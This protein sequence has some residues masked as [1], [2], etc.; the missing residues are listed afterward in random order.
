[1]FLRVQASDTTRWLHPPRS[2]RFWIALFTL[3][4]VSSCSFG[5][6]AKVHRLDRGIDASYLFAANRASDEGLRFGEEFVSTFGPYCYLIYASDTGSAPQRKLIGELVLVVLVGLACAAFIAI[7]PSLGNGI[8]LAAAL[9]LVYAV[10]LQGNSLYGDEYRWFSLL[11]LLVVIAVGAHPVLGNATFLLASLLGGFFLLVKLS[12]GAGAILALS[13]ACVLTRRPRVGVSRI[14][15]LAVGATVGFAAAWLAHQGAFAGAGGFFAGAADVV[16]GYGSAM[17]LAPVGWEKTALCF[18]AFAALT[19]GIAAFSGSVRP[20]LTWLACGTPLFVAWKHA[21]VREDTL[22]VRAFVLFG[23]FAVC[24]V[25]VHLLAGRKYRSALFLLLPV[26]TLF[27]PWSLHADESENVLAGLRHRLLAPFHLPGRDGIERARAFVAGGRAPALEPT[28][29][30]KTLRLPDS[31][32]SRI[33]SAPIDVY[34]WESAYVA[35]NGL[36]WRNRPSPASFATYSPGLDSRNARFF[37]STEKPEYLLWHLQPS[38]FSIDGRHLFWDE[39]ETLRAIFD[40]YRLVSDSDVLLFRNSEQGRLGAPRLFR[41]VEIE[42]G[43]WTAVP[44]A[45]GVLF[46]SVS[47]EPPWSVRLRALLLREDPM[48]L[49][50]RFASGEEQTYRFVPAQAQ[51]GLWMS[52]L[53]RNTK[54]LRAVLSG[55]ISRPRPRALRLHGAWADELRPKVMLSW[56]ASVVVPSSSESTRR[57]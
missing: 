46:A 50:V 44:R 22:H 52:P 55:R 32:R 13:A 8:A 15:L 51:S 37:S 3:S 6:R 28:Q 29:A 5:F 26:A 1:V 27:A 17:S 23:F 9:L 18:G 20:F 2:R 54:E 47:F 31:V 7:L 34:P 10:H 43:E 49:S 21:M 19:T 53:P 48:Y 11:L 12:L 25:L 14:G 56:R 30:F 33:G 42:W 16:S 35:A 38:V 24:M 4:L 41:V 40:S 36:D 45:E 57:R 39:P